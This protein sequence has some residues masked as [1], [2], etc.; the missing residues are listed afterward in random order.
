[1]RWAAG[2]GAAGLAAGGLIRGGVLGSG[3]A[4]AGGAAVVRAATNLPFAALLGLREAPE[5]GIDVSKTVT[6]DASLGDVF[7]Y[8]VAFENFPKFMR[9][10][11]EV[12]RIDENRW[13][14]T[15]EGK[16]GLTFDKAF[17]IGVTDVNEDTTP[18]ALAI[19]QISPDSGTSASDGVTNVASVTV[20]GTI[21][22]ADAGLSITVYKGATLVG[23]LIPI[24]LAYEQAAI[25]GLS[26]EKTLVLKR[27]LRRVYGNMKGRSAT[28][29]AP[30]IYRTP[31]R[32]RR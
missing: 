22:A 19:T 21:G 3:L 8:F 12:R 14:W 7:D 10:V 2:A 26:R 13:H 27:C 29:T 28:S 6:I 25:A 30:A 20:S 1:M 17:T 15:V 23:H 24:A 5:T 18:P 9:H 31:S 11:R 32:D 16:G 4:L